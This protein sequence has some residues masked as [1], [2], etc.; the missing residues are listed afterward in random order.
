L[1]KTI[2]GL[3]PDSLKFWSEWS[4]RIPMLPGKE[5][6]QFKL[7]QAFFANGPQGM[8]DELSRRE[9]VYQ[10]SRL[11]G[12]LIAYIPDD[13]DHPLKEYSSLTE[14]M[15]TLISQLRNTEYQAFFSRFV[16]QKDKGL[17]FT[18]V[19]ERFT[20]FTWHQREPLDM[21]PWW[22]ETAVENPNAEPIT[23]RIHGDLWI[24]LFHERR[25]KAIA[26]ARL[27]AVPTDDEDAAARF[28]RLTS[29]LS[30][31]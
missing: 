23:N 20:T 12:P 26:D 10:Q 14:F 21:G 4:Q 11:S 15:K 8:T 31:G 9:D 19:N 13:P 25:D 18:R 17:F 30:I 16:A 28:K 29:Y 2:D 7:L 22:R 5:Y 24:K 1:K 27:I 3:T 6:E